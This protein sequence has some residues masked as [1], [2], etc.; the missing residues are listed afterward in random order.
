MKLSELDSAGRAVL[1][2]RLNDRPH[3]PL[4]RTLNSFRQDWRTR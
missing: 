1:L 2:D 3:I 4:R